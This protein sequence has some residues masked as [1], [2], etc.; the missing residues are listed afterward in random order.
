MTTNNDLLLC[1]AD[2]TECVVAVEVDGAGK[3]TLCRLI[4]GRIISEKRETKYWLLVSDDTLLNGCGVDCDVAELEGGELRYLV[5]CSSAGELSQV[6]KHIKSRS[7]DQRLSSDC[8]YHLPAW[9]QQYTVSSGVTLY[10]GMEFNDLRRMQVHI[11][12]L[13][14]DSGMVCDPLNDEIVVVALSDS[15]GWELVLDAREMSEEDLLEKAF[16]T[17][18]KRDPDVIECDHAFDFTLRYLF[19]RADY[20]C[21]RPLLGRD[22]S[23]PTHFKGRLAAGKASRSFQVT[24][25][26]GRHVVDS[27]FLLARQGESRRNLRGYEI[28]DA[29][30]ELDI[31]ADESALAWGADTSEM[32]ESD[33]ERL[34][35]R[36]LESVRCVRNITDLLLPPHFEL[37]KYIPL[38]LEQIATSGPGKMI[39]LMLVREHL[40]TGHGVPRPRDPIPR[41]GGAK[42]IFS[43]G[44][45]RN[46]ALADVA[47]MYPTLA[48]RNEISPSGDTA[49]AFLPLLDELTTRRLEL[50]ARAR[51]ADDPQERFLLDARQQALKLLIVAFTGF[52]AEQGRTFNDFEAYEQIVRL[53]RELAYEI[54]DLIEKCGGH[55]IQLIVD[56]FMIGLPDSVTIDEAAAA[57]VADISS[58][59]PE[60]INLEFEGHW[61]TAVSVSTGAYALVADDGEVTLK[62]LESRSREPFANEFIRQ[63][64]ALAVKAQF[65]E[66]RELYLDTRERLSDHALPIELLTRSIALTKPLAALKSV[67]GGTKPA[68]HALA[69]RAEKDDTLP[70]YDQGRRVEF[71]IQA[72][73]A[74]RY[75]RARHPWEWDPDQPDEDVTVLLEALDGAARRLSSLLS[76]EDFALI[77]KTRE[78]EEPDLSAVALVAPTDVRPVLSFKQHEE[79]SQRTIS[80]MIEL[81]EAGYFVAS[82]HGKIPL[83]KGFL[84][85]RLTSED[86]KLYAI[87]WAYRAL[88][89]GAPL[90]FALLTGEANQMTVLDVDA[91]DG[92]EAIERFRD[93][94]LRSGDTFVESG[95][96]GLHVYYSHTAGLQNKNVHVDLDGLQVKV[97]VKGCGLTITGPGSI[98]PTTACPYLLQG[99]PSPTDAESTAAILHA[100]LEVPS[101]LKETIKKAKSIPGG[102]KAGAGVVAIDTGVSK[103]ER[104]RLFREM[105]EPYVEPGNIQHVVK[106]AREHE[107]CGEGSRNADFLSFAGSVHR[108]VEPDGMEEVLAAY[109]S[110]FHY[111]PDPEKASALADSS[112]GWMCRRV[113][114][115]ADILQLLRKKG[116]MA[117]RWIAAELKRDRRLV[118]ATVELL[119]KDRKVRKVGKGR[120]SGVKLWRRSFPRFRRRTVQSKPKSI[121]PE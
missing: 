45:H 39:E 41:T 91:V 106:V 5:E 98:H 53:G 56:G 31:Q 60:G 25:M 24:H 73:K 15:T 61:P 119:M 115:K 35:A 116:P 102:G 7:N 2:D 117:E 27:G 111:P 48:L 99:A 40:R 75:R 20:L 113:S 70:T 86:I 29:I 1:G 107:P 74:L 77:F 105:I 52:L 54:V 6:Q 87:Q 96:G 90:N 95:G 108:F 88:L 22:E 17:I 19:E 51:R 11:E 68:H 4:G 46:V 63:A 57:F 120:S 21:V 85:G 83:D 50:K 65:V 23:T 82:L 79:H 16:E 114:M 44:V 28:V 67:A 30:D 76:P 42:A 3:V 109:T 26:H 71:Y 13:P 38:P 58:A 49:G 84:E 33:P 37:A 69:L 118:R 8:I 103:R 89:K 18:W 100:R 47:S 14:S 92:P 94:Y 32:W 97:E 101:E 64:L 9:L 104:I 12:V 66:L 121:C 93:R 55:V 36:A 110:C 59:L 34:V 112:M 62:G 80:R 43:K 72:G 81:T 78:T 10:E